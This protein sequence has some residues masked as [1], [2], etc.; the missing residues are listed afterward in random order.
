MGPA[1]SRG[2]SSARNARFSALQFDSNPSPVPG[3]WTRG[4]FLLF[5][6]MIKTRFPYKEAVINRARF[7]YAVSGLRI[8]P[9][10]T[11]L[12]AGGHSMIKIE[13]RQLRAI[14]QTQ[15]F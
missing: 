8:C 12:K 4:I 14:P 1:K 3:E 13:Y 2:Y 6:F 15:L 5:H 11:G 9:E 10:I 7:R